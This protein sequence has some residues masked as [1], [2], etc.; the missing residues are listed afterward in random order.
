M[1]SFLSQHQV[2]LTYEENPN[3]SVGGVAGVMNSRGNVV[4]MMPHPDRA[5]FHW[6]GSV[7]GLK[8]FDWKEDFTP[9]KS[10]G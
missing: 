2:W 1:E 7:D 9:P 10:R 8:F 6:M 5:L 4:G 3:G